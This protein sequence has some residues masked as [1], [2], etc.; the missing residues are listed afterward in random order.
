MERTIERK[1]TFCKTSWV[2]RIIVLV[3]GSGSDLWSRKWRK[4]IK[5][6]SRGMLY[7]SFYCTL[8]D[9]FLPISVSPPLN[10]PLLCIS[11]AYA[12]N[13]SFF[14][15]Q[16]HHFILSLLVLKYFFFTAIPDELSIFF[17]KFTYFALGPSFYGSH[18][19]LKTVGL[20]AH[21]N[22]LLPKAGGF[23]DFAWFFLTPLQISLIFILLYHLYATIHCTFDIFF[24]FF[25]IDYH[26]SILNST[27]IWKLWL[28]SLW[29]PSEFYVKIN[30][31]DLLI[32][33]PDKNI[34]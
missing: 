27:P 24:F 23:W 3:G 25:W 20:E 5:P 8:S 21:E 15:L 19:L 13:L 12:N 30:K 17:F 14:I 34:Y 28:H 29:N 10:F 2:R 33:E 16:S 4:A 6:S 22:L 1:E 31:Y 11:I 7:V 18:T 9:I 26:K 32:L